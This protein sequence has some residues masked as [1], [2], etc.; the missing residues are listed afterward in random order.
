MHQQTDSPLHAID[1]CTQRL[2]LQFKTQAFQMVQHTLQILT[3]A[4]TSPYS[5]QFILLAPDTIGV[6][7]PPETEQ[8]F[9]RIVLSP[10]KLV[11]KE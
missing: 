2:D 6:D 4:I 1:E 11:F 7:F 8:Y 9:Q 5:P 3:N 10:Q